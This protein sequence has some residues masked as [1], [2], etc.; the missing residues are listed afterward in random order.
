MLLKMKKYKVEMTE[1]GEK[2]FSVGAVLK[3]KGKYLLIERKIYPPGF[4][5]PSGHIDEGE[6]PEEAL[7]KEVKEETGLKIK[8]MKLIIH[9]VVPWNECS[10]G[11]KIHEWYIYE[12]RFDGELKLSKRETKGGG[13]YTPEEINGMELEEVWKYWFGKLGV[14][15]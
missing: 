11:V 8:D 7:K 9:E 14:L 12:C 5:C 6:S 1:E 2:H 13:W 4:A 10:R 3:N 15:K